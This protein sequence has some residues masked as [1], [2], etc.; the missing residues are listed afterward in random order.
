M[1]TTT[2]PQHPALV[3]MDPRLDAVSDVWDAHSTLTAA[4]P[5]AGLPVPGGSYSGS[6]RAAGTP[7]EA[8]VVQVQDAGVPS[9]EQGAATFVARSSAGTDWSGWE[10]PGAVSHWEHLSYSS[11]SAS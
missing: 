7:T 4:A 11:S 6:L 10:G 2:R 9:G 8:I 1:A 5:R 3:V